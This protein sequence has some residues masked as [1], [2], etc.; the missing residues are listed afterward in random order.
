MFNLPLLEL[1]SS[2]HDLAEW[3]IAYFGAHAL[4]K[5]VSR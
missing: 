5:R 4:L 3:A 1:R 2:G